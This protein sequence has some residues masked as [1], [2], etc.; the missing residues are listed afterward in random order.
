MLHFKCV[1][2]DHLGYDALNYKCV[3]HGHLLGYD[4]LTISVFGMII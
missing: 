1:W 4:A 3:W 2:H